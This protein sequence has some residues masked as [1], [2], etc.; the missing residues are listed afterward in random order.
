[1]TNSTENEIAF[2]DFENEPVEEAKWRNEIAAITVKLQEKRKAQQNGE[3]LRGVHPKSHGCLDANFI[4][5]A[6]V[7]D[8]LRV[9]LFKKTGRYFKAKIRYSNADVLKRS[10]IRALGDDGSVIFENGSRGMAIK[11]LDV[12]GPVLLE[13]GDA[14]NQDFLMVNTPEFAFRNVRD[15]RRLSRVLLSSSDGATP[16]LFF[17]PLKLLSLGIIDQ[18][19]TL[20]PPTNAETTDNL[21]LRELFKTSDIFADFSADDMAGTLSA[22]E[23]V[24]SIKDNKNTVRNPIEAQYFSASPFR[25]GP[26]RVMKFST[27]PIEGA[28]TVE[29]FSSDELSAIDDDYLAAAVKETMTQGNSVT[30]S[31]MVQIAR[32]SDIVGHENEMIENAS[33]PWNEDDFPFT[34]VAKLTVHPHAE[35]TELVD[36]C[37][38]LLFTPWHALAAHEPLG[39]INRLR[40]PVY[41]DSANF[42][43]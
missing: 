24:G 39:G 28:H 34:E 14:K 29:A 30:L 42:R 26:D 3:V 27:M 41:T 1:M 16:D 25:F 21:N 43:R 7:D 8:E 38:P 2:V 20:I 11:V 15:Y 18:S 22:I 13:D 17:L 40:K 32:E 19:G 10:D 9:G 37:K 36:I 4:V 33:I 12:D 6:D 23:V 31:F 5:N 35:N